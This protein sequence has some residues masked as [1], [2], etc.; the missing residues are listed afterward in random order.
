M[1]LPFT[2]SDHGSIQIY[3]SKADLLQHIE[4]PDIGDI[5]VF[6][7]TGDVLRLA[8]EGPDL[9]K[10]LVRDHWHSRWIKSVPVRSVSI[11]EAGVRVNRAD[12][13]AG[14]LKQ[15]L[16]D[17]DMTEKIC[18]KESLDEL[19]ALVKNEFFCKK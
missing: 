6:D 4:S 17:H 2:L 14:L 5:T 11:L 19:I 7:A 9:P 1:K 15:F 8:V 12:E 13:L 10:G 18:G 16:F 3:Q